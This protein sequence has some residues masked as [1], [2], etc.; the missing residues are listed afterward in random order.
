MYMRS[1]VALIA[2][3]LSA[4]GMA[5]FVHQ[6]KSERN[7]LLAER[8]N[9]LK[10]AKGCTAERNALKAA[11]GCTAERIALKAVRLNAAKT[12][13]DQQVK[14]VT[15]RTGELV[16][17]VD[18]PW[19]TCQVS[20]GDGAAGMAFVAA[21]DACVATDLERFKAT[22]PLAD[23]ARL[24]SA[25]ARR[26]FYFMGNSVTRHYAFT[27]SDLIVHGRDVHLNRTAE[28]T[29]CTANAAA[30]CTMTTS[31]SE[32]GTAARQARS[33]TNSS[34][35]HMMWGSVQTAK[36]ADFLRQPLPKSGV[37][38]DWQNH[39]DLIGGPP[40]LEDPG[41]DVCTQTH[42]QSGGQASVL[43]C[44]QQRFRRAS[45]DDVLIVGSMLLNSSA[46]FAASHGPRMLKSFDEDAPMSLLAL[47]HANA[48]RMVET[49]LG[50]FPGLVIFQ[51][52]PHIVMSMH[53]GQKDAPFDIRDCYSQIDALTECAV[54]HFP[55][56]ARFVNLR[57]LQQSQE[58]YYQD[59]IH[60]AGPLSEAAMRHVV[61]LLRPTRLGPRSGPPA[62]RGKTADR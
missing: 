40:Q 42:K 46:Y 16:C 45:K 29:V 44:L 9:A 31:L 13:L 41:R 1:I 33:D 55:L 23:N 26:T 15:A 20:H 35:R 32:P 12:C 30:S 62:A 4:L 25:V 49:L 17:K 34:T 50:V 57:P 8:K 47:R 24:K 18:A 22:C 37:R 52:F 54:R 6:L 39:V 59:S 38:F 11:K 56:R 19:S 61:G 3:S 58:A 36:A 21:P 51:S 7:A 43:S 27:L 5:I 14:A 48:T 28:K 10:A 53:T 2:L 60:H